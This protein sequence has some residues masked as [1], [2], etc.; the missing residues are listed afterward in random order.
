MSLPDIKELVEFSREV[1]TATWG[2]V[3]R[4]GEWIE[5]KNPSTAPTATSTPI[6]ERKFQ[7][8]SIAELV[9]SVEKRFKA[10]YKPAV[11]VVV[12]EPDFLPFANLSLGQQLGASVCRIAKTFDENGATN[13]IST[14]KKLEIENQ[15][16]ENQ[17]A[18]SED[19]DAQVISLTAR[20]IVSIFPIKLDDGSIESFIKDDKIIDDIEPEEI[21][22]YFY[23]V[24]ATGFLVSRNYLL[25][26]YHVF[27]HDKSII[28]E[29]GVVS[30]R[31]EFE[32]VS[33]HDSRYVAEFGYETDS[34]ARKTQSI[35]YNMR[36]VV[37]YDEHLDYALVELDSV[38]LGENSLGRMPGDSFNW[39][40]LLGD[41][42]IVAPEI[43]PDV[44]KLFGLFANS[45]QEVVQTYRLALGNFDDNDQLLTDEQGV[46]FL[47]KVNG[48]YH[49]RIFDDDGAMILDKG[50]D[51]FV[52]NEYLAELISTRTSKNA[53]D[54]T[55]NIDKAIIIREIISSAYAI[56]SALKK[57]GLQ[58][59][60]VNIIQHPRGRRKEIVL[61]NNRLKEMSP[62][63]LEYT[64]DIDFSSSGSPVFNQQWQ[65]VGLHRS[66]IRRS[67]TDAEGEELI[68]ERQKGV[69]TCR[70]VE[71]IREKIIKLSSYLSSLSYDSQKERVERER[72]IDLWSF[73]NSF[74]SGPVISLGELIAANIKGT[75][76]SEEAILSSEKILSRLIVANNL[77][78]N[79]PSINTSSDNEL[80]HFLIK[81]K[82]GTFIFARQ[83][84][85][86]VIQ[87]NVYES[88]TSSTSVLSYGTGWEV[89]SL[90]TLNQP[91]QFAV[92]QISWQGF[93]WKVDIETKTVYRVV[94]SEFGNDSETMQRLTGLKVRGSNDVDNPDEFSIDFQDLHLVSNP[95]R[96]LEI[97]FGE[98]VLSYGKD[99][100]VIRLQP[101][102]FQLRQEY[103]ANGKFYWQVNTWDRTVKEI[104]G[105]GF[106]TIDKDDG[107]V[108]D[109]SVEAIY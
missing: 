68:I 80:Q 108:L 54:D 50:E 9:K 7:D 100:E 86:E 83:A 14:L 79:P 2:L 52:P 64:A 81:F 106:G 67:T 85:T 17:I 94:S 40:K 25:T 77:I 87:I 13:F 88:M 41:T 74:V 6:V 31:P 65:L 47:G 95:D 58:G 93:Y 12:G 21:S 72:L 53:P 62:D 75:P 96:I 109:F 99:W 49:V 11:S 104:L 38:T 1:P 73:Y 69:R 27:S 26:N 23:E 107:T 70:I 92:R 3:K 28:N 91:K 84:E 8:E 82:E 78:V 66:A 15:E 76:S 29:D 10:K 51:S 5:T 63:Y 101:Y 39:I 34:L 45:R 56:D 105:D 18:I 55:Q 20:D 102:I 71:S 103:W 44:E 89:K 43:T 24:C 46:V 33:L 48:F 97:S 36:Q 60:L 19:R 32:S 35:Q 30:M 57:R 90:S 16:A 98:S 22:K 59:D 37:L 42:S 61:S 4:F